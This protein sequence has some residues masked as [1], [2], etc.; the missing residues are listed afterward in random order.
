MDSQRVRMTS[1]RRR[2]LL[3][4]GGLSVAVLV[5]VLMALAITTGG[6]GLVVAALLLAGLGLAGSAVLL[7]LP[8][9]PSV[10]THPEEPAVAPGT[11]TVREVDDLPGFFDAPP[12]SPTAAPVSAGS[13]AGVPSAE[14][15]QPATAPAGRSWIAGLAGAAVLLVVTGGIVAVLAE[16]G[17]QRA[18][19][20]TTAG[21]T[22][23]S[24]AAPTTSRAPLTAA[25][26][27]DL[28][29]ASVAPGGDG[30]T[31]R[32]AFEGLVLE[33]RAVGATFT[34][35]TL[36][37]S[38]DG[39]TSLAHLELPTWNCLTPTAPADPMAAGCT[40]SLTEFADLPAPA[41]ELRE[42]D[43]EFSL[44]GTFATYT[45][46]NGSAPVYTGRSYPITVQAGPDGR[47][48]D[49]RAPAAGELE[50]GGATTPT[51]AD[52]TANQLQ[53]SD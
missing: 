31:A 8:T 51:T 9:A 7:A 45:R 49:G 29:T 30:F 13:P 40:A 19:D 17:P 15:P 25:A 44:T 14:A 41:L 24:T 35:P 22:T 10:V 20:T 6:T 4:G 2:T 50:L 11:P 53:L 38:S 36:E 16:D 18:D 12:G 42:V 39:S 34:Y 3:V 26:A 37:V 5:V 33:P 48:R 43:G 47:V 46:P 32:L 1:G 28:A 23:A 52:R 27:G 21:A